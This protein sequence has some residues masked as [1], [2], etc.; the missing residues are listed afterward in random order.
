M[1]RVVLYP[2][3]KE[4]RRGQTITSRLHR[5]QAREQGRLLAEPR[6]GFPHEDGEGFNLLLQALPLDGKIV[7]R[8]Y[9][10]DEE[11][12]Q[13]GKGK[14]QLQEVG[15]GRVRDQ[16]NEPATSSARFFET[17]CGAPQLAQVGP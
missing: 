15:H 11:E 4:A 1:R 5:H 12:E 6:C 16:L 3:R 7:L 13:K 10:E 17:T 14:P 8:T 2:L 9:K